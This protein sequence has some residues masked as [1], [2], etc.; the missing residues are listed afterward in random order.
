MRVVLKDH[1]LL[2]PLQALL[3]FEKI[4]PPEPLG[5]EKISIRDAVGRVL[6]NDVY[7]P[8]DNPPFSR[9]LVD[10]F[11]VKSSLTPGRFKIIGKVNIGERPLIRV[12]E[13]TA[14]EID[15]GAAIPEGAD[16]VV[17][18]EDVKIENGEVIIDKKIPFGLNIGWLGSDIYK[19]QLIASKGS[20]ITPE[21]ITLFATLGISEIEVFKKPKIYVIV[22][23]NELVEPNKPLDVGKVYEANSYYISS[24][25][26]TLGY[27]VIG[28]KIV[29]DDIN[30]IKNNI[31]EATNI[32]DVV[33]ITGGSSA[34]ERDYVHK[35][36][37]EL[38]EI[39]V[40]GIKIKPGK[41]TI[42]ARINNKP[43]FGLPGNVVSTVM[44]FNEMISKYLSKLSG[45]KN[46]LKLGE[47]EAKFI[48]NVK[49][50]S[51]RITYQPVY[52]I[53]GVKEWLAIP[54]KFESYMIGT[55][56]LSDGYIVLKPN[57]EIKEGEVRK[58]IGK[59]GDSRPT[60][61]GEE[62]ES[63]KKLSSKIRTLFIGS[64]PACKLLEYGGGDILVISSLV[65]KPLK[66]DYVI[67]RKIFSFGDGPNIGYDEWIGLSKLIPNPSIK[68]RYLAL[69]RN[70]IGKSRV[71]APEEI[72]GNN[73]TYVINEDIYIVINNKPL[74]KEVAKILGF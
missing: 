54:I 6:A 67:S 22:T 55:F 62:L 53:R 58:V 42:L 3:K 24:F 17:K 71:I 13:K 34:G 4:L 18:V 57:E 65:C 45:I 43:V 35:A 16:A 48:L 28:Y 1:E 7:S 44:V 2:D 26:K 39:V 37:R 31:I 20:I 70:F 19:D 52:L 51:H 68:L 69:V 29:K 40:H 73:G 36:I 64:I 49:G 5:T 8:I 66:Y 46:E 25:S 32:A 15:T 56:T 61:I 50:D 21:L 11:A 59:S 12:D 63:L 74:D 23:G 9:S 41:P 60:L 10:G 47:I 33:M 30:E 27:E 14:V 38:G 72:I